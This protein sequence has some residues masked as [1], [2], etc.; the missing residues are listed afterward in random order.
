M[1]SFILFDVKT[2]RER[3]F[4]FEMIRKFSSDHSRLCLHV[5]R[6]EQDGKLCEYIF[7]MDILEIFSVKFF[8]RLKN[9]VLKFWHLIYTRF[10]CKIYCKSWQHKDPQKFFDMYQLNTRKHHKPANKLTWA[11]I[12]R[13]SHSFRKRRRKTLNKKW[14]N[15]EIFL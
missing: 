8:W 4:Q 5:Y 7:S 2:R 14:V 3:T 12:Y 11:Y 9:S 6:S 10:T 13:D 15:K 1:R